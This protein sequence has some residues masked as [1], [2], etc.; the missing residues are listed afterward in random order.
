M[1]DFVRIRVENG[2]EVSISRAF[3]AH[4]GDDVE[5]ID[6]PATNRRGAPSGE[7]RK[8]GR[9]VKPKTTVNKEAA[10]KAASVISTPSEPGETTDDGSP[11]EQPQEA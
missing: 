8:G 4:L 3:L 6:S 1:A 5:V 10:S 2:R 7:T 9:R 11:V